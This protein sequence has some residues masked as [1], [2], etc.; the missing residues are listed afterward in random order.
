ML[1]RV[2][3]P[4]TSQSASSKP[5][6]GRNTGKTELPSE[7]G[8]MLKNQTQ[9]E[10][11]FSSPLTSSFQ[12]FSGESQNSDPTDFITS[13]DLHLSNTDSVFTTKN[14]SIEAVGDQPTLTQTKKTVPHPISH[15]KNNHPTQ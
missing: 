9:Q 8:I 5:Q 4:K 13:N 15:P 2:G 12:P 6:S 3:E 11:K 1:S 14:A 7:L 10:K